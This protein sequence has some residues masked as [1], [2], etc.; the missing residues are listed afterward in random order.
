VKPA[1][2]APLAVAL[3]TGACA[4]SERAQARDPMRCERNPSCAKGRGVY[5]DCSQQCSDDP[6][7][8]DR[9][10]SATVDQPKH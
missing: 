3:A 1:L 4:A 10:T 6:A 5:T 2:W 9:C 7:C 8:I